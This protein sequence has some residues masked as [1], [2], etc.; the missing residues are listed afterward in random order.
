MLISLLS[1]HCGCC[2]PAN[3][4]SR[5]PTNFA[6]RAATLERAAHPADLVFTTHDRIA[7]YQHH[8]HD[9][10]CSAMSQQDQQWQRFDTLLAVSQSNCA[11]SSGPS[12]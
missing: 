7:A 10:I 9:I 4:R 1:D 6:N 11:A 2:N 3:L 8:C 12:S 5:L